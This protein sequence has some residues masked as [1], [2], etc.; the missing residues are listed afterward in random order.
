MSNDKPWWKSVPVVLG[1]IA[2]AGL[3]VFPPWRFYSGINAPRAMILRAPQRDGQGTAVAVD[4]PRLA[5][6]L[7]AVAAITAASLVVRA[8]FT[9]PR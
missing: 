4:F 3:L 1:T 8:A 7:A 5:V 2:M 9:R 6:E